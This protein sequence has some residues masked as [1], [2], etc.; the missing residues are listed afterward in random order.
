MERKAKGSRLSFSLYLAPNGSVQEMTA[1][2]SKVARSVTGFEEELAP[3]GMVVLSTDVNATVEKGSFVNK[4]KGMLR[5]WYNR[6]MKNVLV[7]DEMKK[8]VKERGVDTGWSIGNLFRGR[9]FSPKS[10]KTFDEKSFAVDIRGVP[11]DFVKEAARNLGRDFKQESVLVV[12]Y[13]NGR[14]F[15]LGVA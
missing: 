11:F 1:R 12:D 7:D 2:E 4:A 10:Q 5:T 3:G 8:L 9:Y 6:A 13:S 15:I 14:T